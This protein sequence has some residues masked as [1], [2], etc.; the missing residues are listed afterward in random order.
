[1]T[2][3]EIAIDY[4]DVLARH[5]PETLRVRDQNVCVYQH[6]T[7]EDRALL[8]IVGFFRSV[9]DFVLRHADDIQKNTT[10]PLFVTPVFQMQLVDGFANAVATT[11]VG[12]RADAIDAAIEHMRAAADADVEELCTRMR[13]RAP[14]APP[15]TMAGSLPRRN[16]TVKAMRYDWERLRAFAPNASNRERR[17]PFLPATQ[18]TI[19]NELPR[20]HG[21]D[22]A[23][24]AAHNSPQ[25]PIYMFLAA[26]G[27]AESEQIDD[28]MRRCSDTVAPLTLLAVPIGEW[29][30][31]VGFERALSST[32]REYERAAAAAGRPAVVAPDMETLQQRVMQEFGIDM[33]KMSLRDA[34]EP[35]PS[36]LLSVHCTVA[37]LDDDGVSMKRGTEVEYDL[38][39][40]TRAW[41]LEASATSLGPP[42]T[43]H[44][45]AAAGAGAARF[46]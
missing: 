13:E 36:S 17:V 25:E 31:V 35:T 22:F 45:T 27:R 38:T 18:T 6:V 29:G 1:M 28:F 37:E 4:V 2:E 20:P 5:A 42:T 44:G 9:D 10:A 8:R 32:D 43:T 14:A 21:Q 26:F 41:P 16:R 3:G 46:T 19:E 24:V 33:T 39:P 40:Q 30:P 23:V 7:H 11:S 12:A 15:R 34:S